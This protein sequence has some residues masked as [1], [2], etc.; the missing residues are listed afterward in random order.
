MSRS[1]VILLL[2]L[3]AGSCSEDKDQKLLAENAREFLVN[4]LHDSQGWV[5]VHVAEELIS[6]GYREDIETLFLDELKQ[7]GDSP[8]YRIGIW[9]VLSKCAENPDKRGKW[10]E[11]ISRVYADPSQ[12]DRLHAAET[13]AKLNVNLNDVA[14]DQVVSDLKSQDPRMRAFVTWGISVSADPDSINFKNLMGMLDSPE[15]TIRRI[16]AYALGYGR[17]L[18]EAENKRLEEKTFSEPDDSQAKISLLKAAYLFSEEDSFAGSISV[19]AELL[20][21]SP[22]FGR[23]GYFETCMGLAE[24]GTLNDLPFLEKVFAAKVPKELAVTSGDVPGVSTPQDLTDIRSA[25]AFAILRIIQRIEKKVSLPDY[26]VL[27]VYAALMLSI[28]FYYSRKNKSADDFNLGG[29]NMN[30]VLVG[31]SLFAT[32]M[33]TLSYLSYP[34]EMVQ[35]GPVYFAGLASFPLVYYIGGWFLIPKFMKLKVT[36]A[37]EILEIKIGTGVRM[38]AT[39]FFLSL[40]LLWMATIIYATV[41]MAIVPVLWNVRKICAAHLP[42]HGPAHHGLHFIGRTQGC[43][44]NRFIADSH[45][46]TGSLADR[47]Y[48]C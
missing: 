1:I 26:F 39:F 7:R 44:G 8:Q 47:F 2:F 25:S 46:D 29:R 18:P 14:A 35:Y 10:V 17:V 27:L 36:S 38:M 19:K 33:S 4:T 3:I 30:P 13:L 34:G 11:K 40:R 6:I 24:R 42:D 21:N 15:E 23:T 12:P 16:G 32:L 31:L 9:R 5:K 20:R 45:P 43:G 41:E 48:Y 22:A 28:G 37:Y